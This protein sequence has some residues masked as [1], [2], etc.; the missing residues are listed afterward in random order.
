MVAAKCIKEE[1]RTN[2]IIN[3]RI[4]KRFNKAAELNTQRDYTPIDNVEATVPHE[5]KLGDGDNFTDE[6]FGME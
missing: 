1:E 5:N 2:N 3:D 4:N 6:T